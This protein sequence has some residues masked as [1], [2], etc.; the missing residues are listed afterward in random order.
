MIQPGIVAAYATSFIL[1]FL[2]QSVSVFSQEGK[3]ENPLTIPRT[4]DFRVTGDG[5]SPAWQR[6][7]W[8]ELPQREN[9]GVNY[10]TSFKMMYSGTGIYC[11]FF[12]EDQ[13]ITATLQEDFADLYEEDVVE[14]FFH[15]DTTFPVYFEYEL[16]PLNKELPILVPNNRGVFY[17][18]RPW[19][20]EKGRRTVHAVTIQKKGGGVRSWTAECF[21][22][23]TLLKPL[24][25]VPPASGTR[26]RANFY[27]IDYDKGA[28]EWSWK[29]TGPNFHDFERFGTI[30]FE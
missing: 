8:T 23:Y 22:P 1:T 16:S 6:C 26:W 7:A 19:H 14:V 17:G 10:R 11:L 15:P 3:A 9:K 28:A 30:L 27:R 5:L 12:C 25:N 13:T 18:W 21:I 2:L 4:T 29:L 24:P 20:Y